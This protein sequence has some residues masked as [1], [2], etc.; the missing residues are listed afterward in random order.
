MAIVFWTC[1]GYL[2]GGIP[3]AY[4]IGRLF[5]HR[6]IRQVAD[7]NPGAANVIR[8]GGWG[9]GMLAVILEILKGFL[10]V[11][12]A[13]QN[14]LTEWE[15]LPV[16]LAPILGHATQP[17]LGFRGGKALAASGGAW[18]AIIGWWVFPVYAS[19]TVPVL[20]I[21]REHAWAAF[22]GLFALLYYAAFVLDATWLTVFAALNILI[23]AYTHRRELR[24]APSLR[25]WLSHL[26][27]ARRS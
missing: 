20:L 5:V 14:G 7:G 25:P 19:L 13:R 27:A 16:A 23:I 18:L 21:Q 15:L 22:S 8:S 26:L 17:F 10:P 12:L 24:H 11:Y 6:D 4:L 3:F 1:F 9:T 2:V